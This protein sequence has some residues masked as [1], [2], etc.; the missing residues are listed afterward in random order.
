[1]K[2]ALKEAAKQADFYCRGYL[3]NAWRDAHR[4]RAEEI[5]RRLAPDGF[6][7]LL[8]RAKASRVVPED[9]AVATNS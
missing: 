4:H 9:K 5:V 7:K 1:M 6:Q 2:A 8:L 3:P